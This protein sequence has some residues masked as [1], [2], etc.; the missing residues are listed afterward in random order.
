MDGALAFYYSFPLFLILSSSIAHPRFDMD[1]YCAKLYRKAGC[2][3]WVVRTGPY[4]STGR[5]GICDSSI[6][7]IRLL[8]IVWPG[9]LHDQ[10]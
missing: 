6:D 10:K 7:R 3:L 5:R 4:S 8:D 1:A 9:G 2:R